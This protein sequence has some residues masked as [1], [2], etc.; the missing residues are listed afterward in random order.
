MS[1]I[2]GD[3]SIY[4]ARTVVIYGCGV[5]GKRLLG[6]FRQMQVEVSFF[7]D[8][9][10]EMWGREV[11]GVPVISPDSLR[12]KQ[13]NK[14]LLL[15]FALTNEAECEVSEEFPWMQDLDRISYE[16]SFKMLCYF[17]TCEKMIQCPSF[18]A[19]KNMYHENAF[20][21]HRGFNHYA[22]FLHQ[23]N[24]DIFV[25]MIG[26]TADVTIMNTLESCGV[27]F[28]QNHIPHLLNQGLH[29]ERQKIKV[30]TA[31][32][33][34]IARDISGLFELIDGYR[35][36]ELCFSPELFLKKE[37]DIQAFFDRDIDF[38]KNNRNF[39]TALSFHFPRGKNEEHN[40]KEGYIQSF[41]SLFS[42][43][44][45]DILDYPFDKEKGYTIIEDGKYEIFIYQLEKLNEL[46][47]KL[48]QF[49]GIPFD[50]LKK[51]NESSGKWIAESY[52]KAKK[53][54]KFSQEY[55]EICY[56]DPY[57]KHCYSEADIEN[58]KNGW[59]NQI[60]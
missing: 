50:A 8:G 30:I 5:K 59:E 10:R 32:R 37:T 46:I 22:N 23:D 34:P 20:L 45:V 25:I 31:I 2:D 60:K 36:V 9:N 24:I 55:F 47:P 42:E 33:D 19:F 12:E 40:K 39:Q 53:E 51:G 52:K 15:Q 38:T 43:N 11:D 28:F 35:G 7:C 29:S 14:S 48:S 49:I 21:V 41:F 27:P 57:V 17:S 56:N 6:L 1:K 54:L 44:A 58:F 13:K 26:K 16:E 4:K 18:L 3:L